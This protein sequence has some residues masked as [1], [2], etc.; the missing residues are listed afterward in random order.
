[1]ENELFKLLEELFGV[2]NVEIIVPNRLEKTIP[3]M[4]SNN[5]AERLRAEYQQ[6]LIRYQKLCA[7]IKKH[8]LG[9]DKHE[10]DETL[11]KEQREVMRNYLDILIERAT[12]E[13][14]DLL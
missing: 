3:D 9:K 10:H 12:Q 5:P 13:G 6:L 1:M 4:L 7:I 14:W 8:E 11:M 2:G